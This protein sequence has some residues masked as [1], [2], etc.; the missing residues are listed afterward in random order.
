MQ[1]HELRSHPVIKYLAYVGF[2]FIIISFVFFYGWS[3][4]DPQSGGAFDKQAYAQYRSSSWDSFLP[5]KSHEKILPPEV[6]GA[7]SIATEDKLS[8]IQPQIRALLTQQGQNFDWL[9]T[10]EEAAVAAMDQRI[11]QRESDRRDIVVTEE[12]VE[13]FIRSQPGM[14]KNV[15]DQILFQRGISFGQ[16]KQELRQEQTATRVK[17]YIGAEVRVSLHELWLEYLLLSEKISLEIVS[18]PVENYVEKVEVTDEALQAYLEE[19]HETFRVPAKRRYSY[20]KVTRV[21]QRDRI[22]PS[23]EELGEF[24]EEY[25]EDFRKGESAEVDDIYVPMN[26]DQPFAK[27][28]QLI[29]QA[30]EAV[31]RG[32][33]WNALVE[34]LREADEGAS[35]Y[36][37]DIGW[38]ERNEDSIAG[39]GQ[40]YLDR[41]FSLENDSVSSPVQTNFG[42]HLIRRFDYKEG[43]LPALD[44]V[45]DEVLDR[46]KDDRV[47]GLFE[48][49]TVRL[50]DNINRYVRLRDFAVDMGLENRKTSEVL[51]SASFIPEIGSLARDANYIRTLKPEQLS[52]L[53][54][55]PNML[56]ALE[57]A[58]ET[59]SYL[60]PLDEVREE[61]EEAFRR[62]QAREL[63]EEF[64]M[65]AFERAK[66]GEPFTAML[67]DDA[68]TTTVLTDPFTR[69][70]PVLVDPERNL[71]FPLIDFA[72]QTLRIRQGSTG[73]S[74]YGRVAGDPEGYAL[75]R[76]TAIETPSKEDFT[77]TRRRL[78]RELLQ[79]K[80]I[81]MVEEWLADERN[82][83]EFEILTRADD[84]P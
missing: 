42:F 67:N 79:I 53:I 27:A 11:L 4:N 18:Y 20:V 72:Q 36:Y 84:N 29:A 5:W 14:T 77:A 21:D 58:E 6:R 1:L 32:D 39:Y 7:R 31:S 57:V 23:D 66:A 38:L 8:L 41:A 83:A 30:E 24:F 62:V 3:S 34:E 44:D 43:E 73:F 63:A 60:P 40:P 78:E 33:D 75:W 25:Q 51:A 61:A 26:A 65:A 15:L 9:V 55:L 19:N 68:P 16:F 81:T 22:E 46:Y 70:Q 13:N 80:R 54:Q 28:Q 49:E 37:R 59:E 17:N 76:V 47:D 48:E 50:R 64:G 71:S 2:T 82:A 74:P 52:G 45:Y 12:D 56:C 69:L 35:I 10:N